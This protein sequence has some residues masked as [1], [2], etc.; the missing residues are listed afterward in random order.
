VRKGVFAE[1]LW[2]LNLPFF[3]AQQQ[4]GWASFLAASASI[5]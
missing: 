2:W 3:G 4:L 5:Q 1:V